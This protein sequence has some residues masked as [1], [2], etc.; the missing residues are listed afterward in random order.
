[1]MQ[2]W[3]T[4]K[5]CGMELDITGTG[6]MDP[7]VF[8]NLVLVDKMTHQKEAKHQ[9]EANLQQV[10]EVQAKLM[11]ARQKKMKRMKFQ[12]VQKKLLLS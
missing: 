5:L 4:S 1:M 12:E 7:S 11:R 3:F 2:K 10:L 8:G 9:E 6:Y